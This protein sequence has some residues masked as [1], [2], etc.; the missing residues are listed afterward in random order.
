M[1][2]SPVR[3]IRTL[4]STAHPER[5]ND[6]PGDLMMVDV[7]NGHLLELV[8]RLFDQSRIAAAEHCAGYDNRPV[9]FS[10][11]VTVRL[12]ESSRS[13]ETTVL[14]ELLEERGLENCWCHYEG[15]DLFADGCVKISD[16]EVTLLNEAVVFHCRV[17]H[18]PCWQ[19]SSALL[20]D[21]L[22]GHY[23]ISNLV[24]GDVLDRLMGK[25]KER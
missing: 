4:I 19:A 12:L 8:V 25:A 6:A 7:E 15:P 18:G 13:I 16:V 9:R 24:P 23:D 5:D 14:R 17:G 22:S 2:K 20:L 3:M 21:E 1:D 10:S 11:P